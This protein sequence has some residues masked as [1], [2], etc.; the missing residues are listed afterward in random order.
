MDR[1]SKIL[2]FIKIVFALLLVVVVII[3]AVYFF[4]S[5]KV[6]EENCELGHDKDGKCIVIRRCSDLALPEEG[7]SNSCINNIDKVCCENMFYEKNTSY[8][9]EQDEKPFYGAS[10]SLEKVDVRRN[11]PRKF[12]NYIGCGLSNPIDRVYD[13]TEVEPGEF[14]FFVA[15]KYL[16]D[17]AEGKKEFKFLCGGSLISGT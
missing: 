16:A 17:P 4:S 6:N 12:E 11:K 13:G 1:N 14:P 5:A 3:L 7:E 2:L 8:S 15:L 9:G 10:F